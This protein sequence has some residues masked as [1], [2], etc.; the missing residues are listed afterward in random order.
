[1]RGARGEARRE[2]TDALGLADD[3]AGDAVDLL[4]AELAEGLLCLV[5]LHPGACE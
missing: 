3:D 5:R 2:G 4:E 1:M